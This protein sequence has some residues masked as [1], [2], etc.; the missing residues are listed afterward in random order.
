MP[1]YEGDYTYPLYELFTSKIHDPPEN[2]AT[3]GKG[4]IAQT[5]NIAWYRQIDCRRIQ[6]R[7]PVISRAR[8]L[9]DGGVP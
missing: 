5:A 9:E 6:Q 4:I 1:A 2:F 8:F 7:L 3:N